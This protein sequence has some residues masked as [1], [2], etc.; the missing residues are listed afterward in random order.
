MRSLTPLLSPAAG[1]RQTGCSLEFRG[2]RGVEG[3]GFREPLVSPS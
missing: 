3:L 2:V 1:G